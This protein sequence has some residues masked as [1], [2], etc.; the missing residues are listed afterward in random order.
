LSSATMDYVLQ[1]SL[2]FIPLI[3]GDVRRTGGFMVMMN[4][5]RFDSAQRT[6]LV[7]G[8]FPYA[9]RDQKNGES[10]CGPLRYLY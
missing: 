1:R 3:K 5:P 7:K 2:S 6:S 4:P 9:K 8:G 10:L